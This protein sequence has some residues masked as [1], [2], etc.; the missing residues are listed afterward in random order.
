MEKPGDIAVEV[1]ADVAVVSWSKRRAGSYLD[2]KLLAELASTLA[3]LQ[4]D[5]SIS[6]ICLAGGDS[7]FLLGADPIL[8]G[9]VIASEDWVRLN[10]FTKQ[11]HQLLAAL[12]SSPKQTTAWLRGPAIGGGLELALACQSRVAAPMAKFSMPETGLGIYPG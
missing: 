4:R 8:F 10:A 2:E 12:A 3:V 1:V 6:A 7:A 9:E 11:A 5:S